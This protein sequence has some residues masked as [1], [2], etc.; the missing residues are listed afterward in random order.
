MTRY[1]L[2]PAAADDLDEIWSFIGSDDL[3]AAD[4][5]IGELEDACER[6]AGS[7]LIG[8]LREDLADA[9]FLAGSL[10]PDRLSTRDFSPSDRPLLA[11]RPRRAESPIG[12]HR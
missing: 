7:P 5:V 11:L 1:V 8:H 4:R 10:V 9:S 2:S 6:L 12:I 3:D